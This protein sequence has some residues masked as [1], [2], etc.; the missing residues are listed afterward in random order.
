[1]KQLTKM[2]GSLTAKFA[3]LLLLALGCAGSAWGATE[4]GT[5]DALVSALEDGGEITLTANIVAPDKATLTLIEGTVLD[6]GGNTLTV[7]GES[8]RITGSTI[9]NGTIAITTYTGDTVADGLFDTYGECSMQDVN[10]TSTKCAIYAIF[11]IKSGNLSMTRC[12]ITI[13]DNNKAG[14]LIYFNST[15]PSSKLTM[16]DCTVD[17]TDIGDFLCN[18]IVHHKAPPKHICF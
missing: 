12:N 3:A 1:M 16:T 17:C 2:I 18:G 11:D 4:V 14:G 6:L 9:K 15:D 10:F 13:S 5:Y 8:G 7:N